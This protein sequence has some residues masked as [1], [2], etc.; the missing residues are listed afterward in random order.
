MR[1]RSESSLIRPNSL[2]DKSSRTLRDVL[3]DY[4][5]LKL[6]QLR[7]TEETRRA[8]DGKR[9]VLRA[10]ANKD[11][12]SISRGDVVDAVRA[13][14]QTAPIAANRSLAYRTRN[15]A[16]RYLLIPVT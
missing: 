9:G 8:L 16:A 10:F 15:T 6:S 11:I 5:R 3:D 4:E 12:A 2:A 14:A 7:T 1:H 13:H